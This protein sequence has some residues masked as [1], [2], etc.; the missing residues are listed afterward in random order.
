[1]HVYDETSSTA[2]GPKQGS[3]FTGMLFC[4]VSWLG[5]STG[6]KYVQYIS[7]CLENNCPDFNFASQLFIRFWVL[8]HDV[9]DVISQLFLK[10]QP[11][12]VAVK[13]SSGVFVFRL[14]Y[15]SDGRN[16]AALHSAWEN[17][18]GNYHHT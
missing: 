18:P 3:G 11:T 17:E 14:S 1:M 12:Q 15:R 10:P 5:G 8:D 16:D 2:A 4:P 6:Y 7:A 9:S 13:A